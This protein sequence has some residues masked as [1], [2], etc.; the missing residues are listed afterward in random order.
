MK[1]LVSLFLALSLVLGMASALAAFNETGLPIV[2]EPF[3]FSLMV[4]ESG[5]IE[6]KIMLPIL[7]EQTGVKVDFQAFP[8]EAAKEKMAVALSSGD[9]PH[10]IGGWLL[11]QKDVLQLAADES[12]LPLEDLIAQYAPNMTEMLDSDPL[13]RKTYTTPDGH[14][15]TIPYVISEPMVTFKPYINKAWLDRLGLEVPA[16]TEEL[17]KVLIAFRDEDANGNGIKDDEIPFSADANNRHLGLLAGWFGVDA[18]GDGSRAYFELVDGKLSFAANKE[19]YKKF[20]EYFADLSQEN[21]L[22]PELFTQ[23]LAQW[24]AKGNQDLYGVCL[25]YGAGDFLPFDEEGNTPF[26]PLPV[27]KSSDDVKP[28]FHRNSYGYTMFPTQAVLTDKCDEETA[29]V[30]IRWFDNVFAPDNSVQIQWGPYDIAVKKLSD[31]LFQEIDRTDWDTEK[32]EKYSWSNYYTQSLPK[33]VRLNMELVKDPSAPPKYDE[34]KTGD[35]L[36]GPYLNEKMPTVWPANEDDV[37]RSA[38]LATDINDYVK[39]Q[40]ALFA[41]GKADVATEWDA[42]VAHLDTLGLKELTEI[43]ARSMGV[44][45]AD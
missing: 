36:Y 11:S 17:K 28:L 20:L 33:F 43:H 45:V 29:K 5:K 2:T 16:T 34:M 42:Y 41:T 25:A 13:V 30:I 18:A 8:Y 40:L 9:Y 7:E 22:D 23:D 10:V 1:K 31:V 4:D 27:L 35:E 44:E 14:I 21:L 15:Y 39:N 38:E 26:V 37:K 6:D 32:K 12:I 24:K 3:T 19:G